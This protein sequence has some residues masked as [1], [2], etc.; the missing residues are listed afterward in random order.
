M[1]P[2]LLTDYFSMKLDLTHKSI[3]FLEEGSQLGETI[4]T[5]NS[6]VLILNDIKQKIEE[7]KEV[8]KEW[9]NGVAQVNILK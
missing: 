2:Q 8:V 1:E 3:Q 4:S 5:I 9:K 7:L 6:N